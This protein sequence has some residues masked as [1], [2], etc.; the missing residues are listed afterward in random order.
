MWCTLGVALEC[1]EETLECV[2]NMQI[3]STMLPRSGNR[4]VGLEWQW[5]VHI[6]ATPANFWKWPEGGGLWR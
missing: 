2:V 6:I 5:S 4:V 1:A 3:N